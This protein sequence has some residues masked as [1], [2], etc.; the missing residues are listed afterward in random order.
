GVMCGAAAVPDQWK[1]PL[2]DTVR[3]AV[4]GFDGVRISE[5]AERTLRLA[6]AE[7]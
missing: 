5:L 4:F 6:Q 3:S 1:E 7:T 2:E